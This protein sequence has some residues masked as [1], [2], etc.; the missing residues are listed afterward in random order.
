MMRGAWLG[1]LLELAC[2]CVVFILRVLVLGVVAWLGVL[3]VEVGFYVIQVLF[4]VFDVRVVIVH[5]LD[6]LLLFDYYFV[7]WC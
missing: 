7:G 2:C 1:L 3:D 4:L 5:V 6:R